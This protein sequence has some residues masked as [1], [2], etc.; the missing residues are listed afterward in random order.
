M[1]NFLRRYTR[2]PWQKSEKM[3][4]VSLVFSVPVSV[5]PAAPTGRA[6]LT[7]M[8]FG[9]LVP[10][11]AVSDDDL[12]MAEKMTRDSASADQP[13]APWAMPVL[14]VLPPPP[15]IAAFL[16]T[17]VPDAMGGAATDT[18]DP[19]G[20]T[21]SGSHLLERL[22]G[23]APVT[24]GDLH[25]GDS[26]IGHHAVP[27][28]EPEGSGD[29]PV[30]VRP[31][32]TVAPSE[33]AAGAA[34]QPDDADRL[35]SRQGGLSP[36]EASRPATEPSRG[37]GQMLSP[38][39]SRSVSALSHHVPLTDPDRA[40]GAMTARHASP[41][42]AEA[43]LSAAA[44]IPQP[45]ARPGTTVGLAEM[46]SVHQPVPRPPPVTGG[47]TP[48]HGSGG[49]DG[50]G[51]ILHRA[52]EAATGNP[53]RP[54]IPDQGPA[55][56]LA[57]WVPADVWQGQAKALWHP[58]PNDPGRGDAAWAPQRVVTP[59]Q[60]AAPPLVELQPRPDATLAASVGSP[61]TD[62][63]SGFADEIAPLPAPWQSASNSPPG[64]APG[65]PGIPGAV[66]QLLVAM[67]GTLTQ[68][69]GGTT[70]IALSPAE[71][72]DVSI[73]LRADP[74]DPERMVVMLVF[75]RP[76][77]LDL[78]RRHADQL[79][80]ALR[81]AGYAR[82][83]IDFGQTATGGFASG[84]SGPDTPA[85]PDSPSDETRR[86]DIPGDPLSPSPDR[87]R[88]ASATSLDLRL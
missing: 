57:S 23:P 19:V 72:G 43:D 30:P 76:E 63:L 81:S 26:T 13:D 54:D 32:E 74:D 37:T 45:G 21:G 15:P 46:A 84:R 11:P 44:T 60:G 8:T 31:G 83:E 73:S 59:A 1:G 33:K 40:T 25:P 86:R 2:C 16:P 41:P 88:T 87:R 38:M 12:A 49:S 66:P 75:D 27:P 9:D 20:R 64:A 42:S 77:T 78:F 80:D 79:A 35:S 50:P 5:P 70:E 55:V 85:E 61:V 24:R 53:S 7:V 82:A 29:R 69:P 4:T 10:S 71:L 36:D 14:P 52:E 3:Q 17:A 68:R 62:L 58:P 39:E 67:L 48:P 65:A 22:H 18:A 47:L 6:E 34:G 51:P 56:K 28:D